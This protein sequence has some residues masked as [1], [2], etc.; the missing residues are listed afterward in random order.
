MKSETGTM[1][2]HQRKEWLDQR[3]SLC[4]QAG[5]DLKAFNQHVSEL[6]REVQNIPLS[7]TTS[8]DKPKSFFK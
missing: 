2:P 1:S 6:Q 4:R 5:E 7:F 8:S 3:I